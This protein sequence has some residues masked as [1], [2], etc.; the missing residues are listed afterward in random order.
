MYDS[1]RYP[2]P[3]WEMVQ[4]FLSAQRQGRVIAVPEDG[5][6]Q[7]TLIP[8]VYTPAK[9]P[10][11]PHG[12]VTAHLVQ[13]DPVCRALQ[14]NPKGA[15]L[16]DQPLAFIPHDLFHPTDGSRAMLFFRTVLLQGRFHI[17]RDPA[18]VAEVL[19]QMLDHEEPDAPHQRVEN[20]PVY[21]ERLARLAAVR[22][23]VMHIQVKW[24]LAQDSPPDIRQK[25]VQYLTTRQEPLDL[26]TAQALEEVWRS[27]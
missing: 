3:P 27:S 7:T 18:R 9:G 16:V 11:S 4:S 17:D 5:F 1:P 21:G 19:D 15:F 13:D 23:D 24:K 6:P 14:D 20:G 2:E 10:D 12:Q 22:L 26:V 25:I 8:Y